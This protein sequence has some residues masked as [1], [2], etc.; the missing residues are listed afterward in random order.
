MEDASPTLLLTRPDVQSRAFLA[1]CETALGGRIPTV[2]SPLMHII[3]V[4]DFPD[5]DQFETLIVTSAHAV[6]RLS[7]VDGL[8]GRRL[9]CVGEATAEMAR[10]HGADATAFGADVDTFLS[11]AKG[12]QAPCLYVRGRH[13]RLDLT[14]ALARQGVLTSEVVVYDQVAQ[15]LSRAG[16][17]LLSGSTPVVAPLFSARTAELLGRSSDIRAPMKVIAMSEGVASAWTG[18]GRVETV[19]SPTAV[20]MRDAVV[21]CY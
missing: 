15:P 21:R 4:G 20:S 8:R 18:G 9:V 16:E 10:K 2:V 12:L 1:E 5:L 3:D 11:K 6:R 7:D 17:A 14:A 13:I 19:A